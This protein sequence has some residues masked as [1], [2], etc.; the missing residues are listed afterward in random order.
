MLWR[1]SNGILSLVRCKM[2]LDGAPCFLYATRLIYSGYLKVQERAI[3]Y[4]LIPE[5]LSKSSALHGVEARA[6]AVLGFRG[7]GEGSTAF[8][9]A[10]HA[11]TLPPNSYPFQCFSRYPSE[12]LTCRAI[13][14]L[15]LRRRR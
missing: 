8:R 11:F 3:F 10:K 5:R 13:G 9:D 1:Q 7:L 2:S 4:D 14:S 12:Q 15:P 6:Q